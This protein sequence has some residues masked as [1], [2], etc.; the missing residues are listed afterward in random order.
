MNHGVAALTL[1]FGSFAAVLILLIWRFTRHLSYGRT[2]LE[3]WLGVSVWT[4][5]NCILF[6]LLLIGLGYKDALNYFPDMRGLVPALFLGWFFGLEV[7]VAIF[8]V[9][10]AWKFTMRL[11]SRFTKRP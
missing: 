8:L 2:I 3:A 6:P 1:N 10:H 5:L 9:R 11:V 4:L 7:V